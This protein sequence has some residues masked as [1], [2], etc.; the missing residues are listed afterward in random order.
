MTDLMNKTFVANGG[1][2]EDGK[3]R[4]ED[5]NNLVT[6]L[7][8]RITKPADPSHLDL[9]AFITSDWTKVARSWAE[10]DLLYVEDNEGTLEW[11]RLPKGSDGQVLSLASGLPSWQ[12]MTMPNLK[13]VNYGHPYTYKYVTLEFSEVTVPCTYVDGGVK[14]DTVSAGALTSFGE[15]FFDANH[16]YIFKSYQSNNASTYYKT[17]TK[18]NGRYNGTYTLNVYPVISNTAFNGTHNP[19]AGTVLGDFGSATQ[20]DL[21]PKSAST[22][23]WCSIG[24]YKASSQYTIINGSGN[25][26]VGGAT[27]GENTTN[28]YITGLKG[29]VGKMLPSTMTLSNH[30]DE[31]SQLNDIILTSASDIVK[32]NNDDDLRFKGIASSMIS[33]TRLSGDYSSDKYIDIED[34]T[35]IE[36]L[37]GNPI[38][39][40]YTT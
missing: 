16:R 10:G 12:S 11:Q 30:T 34:I 37:G 9:L 22:P 23:S 29:Y 4:Y 28:M 35:Q 32:I 13:W 1:T 40:F 8:N 20:G 24:G 36:V 31:F 18:L 3:W 25:L 26:Y 14:H 38:F 21:Y 15:S 2:T 6:E 39:Q 5:A 19:A 27:R 7:K 17:D 33:V